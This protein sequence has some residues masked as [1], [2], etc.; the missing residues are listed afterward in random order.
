MRCT[1]GRAQPVL[2]HLT[3]LFT[4]SMHPCRGAVGWGGWLAL[5]LAGD[6]VVGGGFLGFC[7]RRGGT[8]VAN[9]TTECIWWGN[10]GRPLK[11]SV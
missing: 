9:S 6:H 3:P 5:D 2:P 8:Q 4:A 1:G 11:G 7:F 10:A